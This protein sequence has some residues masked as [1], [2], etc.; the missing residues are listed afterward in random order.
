MNNKPYCP[1]IKDELKLMMM[2]KMLSVPKIRQK[3]KR[4]RTKR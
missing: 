3:V 4:K 1:E 2:M